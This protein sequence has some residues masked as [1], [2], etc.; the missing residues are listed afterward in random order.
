MQIDEAL[1][2]YPFSLDIF[3]DQRGTTPLIYAVQ[4]GFYEIVV[5]L[6]FNGNA[7]VNLP[8]VSLMTYW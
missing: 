2:R 4:F 8:N 3:L 1:R 7:D 5:F 6:V